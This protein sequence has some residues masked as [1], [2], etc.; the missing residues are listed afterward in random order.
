MKSISI[1]PLFVFIFAHQTFLS[2]I[3][4]YSLVSY[5]TSYLL[6]I[7]YYLLLKK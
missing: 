5:F 2:L 6:P 1:F 4:V 3:I 7:T